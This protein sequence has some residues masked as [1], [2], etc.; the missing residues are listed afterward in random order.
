MSEI[1]PTQATM[2]VAMNDTDK[3]KRSSSWFEAMADAWGKALDKQANTISE[4]S[5]ELVDGMD[6]PRQ[7]SMLT[8][9]SLRMQFLSNSSHTA[10]TAVGSSLE[11][12]AR[13]Q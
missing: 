13:K 6:S 12:M 7:V 4:M 9:E 8:A 5:S 2:M 1:T 10:I 11:T 3:T